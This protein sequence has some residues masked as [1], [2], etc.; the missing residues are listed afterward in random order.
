MKASKCSYQD[1]LTTD[2]ILKLHRLLSRVEEQGQEPCVYVV[3][4]SCGCSYRTAVVTSRPLNGKK[5]REVEFDVPNG[6][7]V[8]ISD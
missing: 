2:D 7:V 8:D 5:P 3:A 4:C 1:P 6:K